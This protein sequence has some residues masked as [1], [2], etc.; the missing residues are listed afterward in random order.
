VGHWLNE[1]TI[2]RLEFLEQNK[3]QCVTSKTGGVKMPDPWA[4]VPSSKYMGQQHV[5]GQTVDMWGWN[6]TTT[7]R[8]YEL[9]VADGDP[10]VPLWTAR[11]S[12]STNG[13]VV[14]RFEE[15]VG[16]FSNTINASFFQKPAQCP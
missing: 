16:N 7:G 3:T 5:H 8:H 2:W 10:N 14:I 11:Q 1:Q 6:D 9:A 4:W 13:S 12:F 15:R